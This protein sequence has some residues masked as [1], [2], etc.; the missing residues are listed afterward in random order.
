MKKVE[1]KETKY[2]DNEIVKLTYSQLK[3]FHLEAFKQGYESRL[4]CGGLGR[5]DGINSSL[6]NKALIKSF[7]KE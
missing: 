1:I 2:L 3:K 7:I 4:V 5:L 6:T